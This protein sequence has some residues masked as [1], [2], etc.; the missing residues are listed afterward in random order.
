M[1]V[2]RDFLSGTFDSS[3]TAQK[4]TTVDIPLPRNTRHYA[5]A[6]FTVSA[7]KRTFE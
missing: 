2:G 6:S 4:H 3:T 1:T 5:F 7:R